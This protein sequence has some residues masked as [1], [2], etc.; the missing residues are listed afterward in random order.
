VPA[1]RP[2]IPRPVLSAPNL[3]SV[4]APR[5]PRKL[6]L[7]SAKS[8]TLVWDA[9]EVNPPTQSLAPGAPS[10]HGE[11]VEQYRG[12]GRLVRPRRSTVTRRWKLRLPSSSTL[13]SDDQPGGRYWLPEI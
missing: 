9:R 4:V 10:R 5:K 7:V 3:P 6:S 2:C 8:S 1:D 13:V 12:R 11:P